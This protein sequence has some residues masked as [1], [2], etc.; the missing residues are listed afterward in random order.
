MYVL[1][2]LVVSLLARIGDL[3]V[4]RALVDRNP[5]RHPG[6]T[7]GVAESPAVRPDHL[8]GCEQFEKVHDHMLITILCWVMLSVC[9]DQRTDLSPY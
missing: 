2:G 1:R 9:T 3:R 4:R 8:R 7:P 5:D 6:R